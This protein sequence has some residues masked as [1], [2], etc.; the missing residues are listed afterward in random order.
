MEDRVVLTV[1]ELDGLTITPVV[2]DGE[3]H[4]L[5]FTVDTLPGIRMVVSAGASREL[6]F[7]LGRIV[8]EHS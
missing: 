5:V 8:M 6:M 3:L 7:A 4:S 1:G 2:D